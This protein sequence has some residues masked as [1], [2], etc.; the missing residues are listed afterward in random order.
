M[1]RPPECA[2]SL[3]PG[4]SSHAFNLTKCSVGV[5]GATGSN[6][7]AALEIIKIKRAIDKTGDPD[8][9]DYCVDLA[10]AHRVG[11]GGQGDRGR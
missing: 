6:A 10:Q 4:P 7:I 1:L 11:R 2:T 3:P 8:R 9:P 5:A